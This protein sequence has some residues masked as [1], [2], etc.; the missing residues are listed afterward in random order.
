ME[1]VRL[2]W[3]QGVRASTHGYTNYGFIMYTNYGFIM[4]TQVRMTKLRVMLSRVPVRWTRLY[5]D[6]GSDLWRGAAQN[7]AGA[8]PL[9]HH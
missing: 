2:S 4:Y 8:E 1:S 7:A 9:D 6:A 5:I 3:S